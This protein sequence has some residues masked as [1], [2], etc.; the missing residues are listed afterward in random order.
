MHDQ[1]RSPGNN[2]HLESKSAMA[3][4]PTS[5]SNGANTISAAAHV[6]ADPAATRSEK[7]AAALMMSQARDIPTA[8][9]TAVK[10]VKKVTPAAPAKK[11][12]KAKKA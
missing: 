3:K 5:N 10:A 12:K 7:K 1:Q 2:D 8:T 9:A 11:A 6:L 4:K